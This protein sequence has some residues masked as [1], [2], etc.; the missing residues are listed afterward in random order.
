MNYIE[1]L[2]LGFPMVQASCLGDDSIYENLVASPGHSVPSKAELDAV[3][4]EQKQRAVWHLIQ[5]YRESHQNG[6]VKVDGLWFHSDQPSR[7]QYLALTMAGSAGMFPPNLMWKTMSGDFTMLT[8][9]LVGGIFMA[10]VANDTSVFTTAEV[11]KAAMLV[12]SDPD[13]YDFSAGWAEKF[14]MSP[15]PI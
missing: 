12:S 2:A 10:I 3:C 11:H 15:V 7:I 5:Q 1:A 8:Q 4:L 6:G 14:A 13:T 9:Q